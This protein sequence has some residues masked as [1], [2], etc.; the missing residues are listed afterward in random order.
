[1]KGQTIK[2]SPSRVT[3]PRG[4]LVE[5]IVPLQARVAPAR[6]VILAAAH[7]SLDEGDGTTPPTK[8][9][10]QH[11]VTVPT[12]APGNGEGLINLLQVVTYTVSHGQWTSASIHIPFFKSEEPQ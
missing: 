4:D 10:E 5:L 6:S 1:M 3:S 11:I 8:A 2:L 7:A 12:R 9:F